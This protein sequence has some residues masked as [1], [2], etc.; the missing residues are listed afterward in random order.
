M[1]REERENEAFEL[2]MLEGEIT[3]EWE[4]RVIDVKGGAI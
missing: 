1:T 3:C 2:R 4:S